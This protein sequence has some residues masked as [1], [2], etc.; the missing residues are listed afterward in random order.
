[1]NPSLPAVEALQER[2]RL[3]DAAFKNGEFVRLQNMQDRQEL[4]GQR[5]MVCGTSMMGSV[6]VLMDSGE[7]LAV[8]ADRLKTTGA[9]LISGS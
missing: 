3:A 7:R 1:M 2:R 8:P 5:G 9:I 6:K 4:N